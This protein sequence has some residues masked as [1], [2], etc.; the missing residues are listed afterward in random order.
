VGVHQGVDDLSQE[1]RWDIFRPDAIAYGVLSSL[2]PPLT[3]EDETLGALN[4]YSSRPDAFPA[5]QREHVTALAGQ[6]AAALALA[7]RHVHQAQ[8]QQQLAEAMASRSII[9]QAIGVLMA[10]QGCTASTRV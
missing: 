3:V 4:L 9:D 8:M 2:S 1:Q 6:C 7:L 10:Q 5:P